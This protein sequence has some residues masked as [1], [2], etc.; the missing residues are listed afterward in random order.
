MDSGFKI[1]QWLFLEFWAM[2]LMGEIQW[3][4]G[5]SY[6]TM[7]VN[8]TYLNLKNICYSSTK[9]GLILE[10][11]Y[12]L[13]S[14]SLFLPFQRL[15]IATSGSGRFFFISDYNT[16]SLKFCKNCKKS[17]EIIIYSNFW[18]KHGWHFFSYFNEYK[19]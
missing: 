15:K 6:F 13:I 7:F 17:K 9:G 1:S 10:F 12:F 11:R 8:R 4:I 3:I 18:K 2:I 14:K 5:I 19:L 16:I